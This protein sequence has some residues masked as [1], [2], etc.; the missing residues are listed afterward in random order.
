MV[1]IIIA[2]LSCAL[3]LREKR[4]EPGGRLEVCRGR[5]SDLQKSQQ[6]LSLLQTQVL[7]IPETYMTV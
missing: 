2:A 7:S 3:M 5:A 6:K 4:Q 1:N